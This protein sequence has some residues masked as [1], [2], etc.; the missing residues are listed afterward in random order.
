MIKFVQANGLAE[1]VVISDGEFKCALGLSLGNIAL[2]GLGDEDLASGEEI[3]KYEIQ[4]SLTE[5]NCLCRCEL[6]LDTGNIN[7]YCVQSI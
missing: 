7:R 6:A 4:C 2:D 3:L 1:S 5:L